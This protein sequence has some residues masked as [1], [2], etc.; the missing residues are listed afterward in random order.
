MDHPMIAGKGGKLM[1]NSE[2]VSA[3]PVS[4]NTTAPVRDL[5]LPPSDP[6]AKR[7]NAALAEP[8]FIEEETLVVDGRSGLS[9][10]QVVESKLSR[11]LEQTL[12]PVSHLQ[13]RVL[14]R[15]R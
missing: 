8:E 13:S 4:L 3:S 12:L 5:A 10:A 7:W 15:R 1:M 11:K 2:F 9:P 6:V 14:L